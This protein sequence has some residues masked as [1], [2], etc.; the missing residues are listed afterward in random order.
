M[1]AVIIGNGDFTIKKEKEI[2]LLGVLVAT[3]HTCIH[4]RDF[5]PR[6]PVASQ[7]IQLQRQQINTHL[8]PIVFAQN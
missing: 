8:V 2:F 4:T 5:F 1:T 6:A 3:Q 7:N